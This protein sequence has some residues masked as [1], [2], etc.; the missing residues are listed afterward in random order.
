MWFEIQLYKRGMITGDQLAA[1]IEERLSTAP[2]IG[3]LAILSKRISMK[4]LFQVLHRQSETL[5][6]F[7]EVAIELGYLSKTDVAELLLEQQEATVDLTEILIDS[8]LITRDAVEAAKAITYRRGAL[9]AAQTA[10]TPF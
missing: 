7:G 2:Q 6:P 3:Q 8:E 4:E 10:C 1:A 5:E 9:E